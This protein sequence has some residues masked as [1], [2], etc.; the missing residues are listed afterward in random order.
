MYKLRFKDEQE[1][2]EVLGSVPHSVFGPVRVRGELGECGQ[3]EYTGEQTAEGEPVI[4][5][6]VAP[7]VCE[8][9][10]AEMSD[11]MPLPTELLEYAVK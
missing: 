7:I 4:R 3:Y 8:G 9:Y 10:F 5:E 6:L 2:L 11:D 1:M